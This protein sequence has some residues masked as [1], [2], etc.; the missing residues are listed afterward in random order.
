MAS[1]VT[2]SESAAA[3]A[4]VAAF[5]EMRG[6]APLGVFQ[7]ENGRRAGA[8][9]TPVGGRTSTAAICLQPQVKSARDN[10]GSHWMRSPTYICFG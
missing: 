4:V 2:V 3:V 1:K 5:S 7:L 10:G 9:G 8:V 6:F